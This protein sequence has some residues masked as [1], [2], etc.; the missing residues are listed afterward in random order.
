[1]IKSKTKEKKE[2]NHKEPL[3]NGPNWKYNKYKDGKLKNFKRRGDKTSQQHKSYLIN[4]ER[5]IKKIRKKWS[6]QNYK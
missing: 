4:K 3:K 5:D 2:I 1:M 6:G